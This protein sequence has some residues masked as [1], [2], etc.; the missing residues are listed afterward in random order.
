MRL[1]PIPA[2]PVTR[3]DAPLAGDRAIQ[4]R[5]DRRQLPLAA[6]PAS[7]PAGPSVRRAHAG[8]MQAD[9]PAPRSATPLTRTNCALTQDR[10][11]TTS[12]AV[13]S[14]SITP[15]GRSRRTPSAGHPDLLT[16]R[17]V[18]SMGQNQFPR[19]SLARSSGPPA[20]QFDAILP[21]RTSLASASAIFSWI[22]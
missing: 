21:P 19:R 8:H 11:G 13:D 10:G 7:A 12:R 15:P 3:D 9:T 2:G 17:G 16:D 18:I 5:A 22:S 14:L 6:R 20:P 1:L 4:D